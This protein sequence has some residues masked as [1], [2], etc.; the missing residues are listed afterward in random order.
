MILLDSQMLAI[1]Q[2]CIKL[3]AIREHSKKDLLNKLL[4]R[5]F[6]RDT[7]IHVIEILAQDAGGLH[8]GWRN[9]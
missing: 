6:D 3:L 1:K 4:A 7:S 8:S 2:V 9:C 5:G